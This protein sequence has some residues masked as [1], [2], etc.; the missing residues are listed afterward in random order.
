M[1]NLNKYW[2]YKI[3][4][5]DFYLKVPRK[6]KY[7]TTEDQEEIKYHKIIQLSMKYLHLS[8]PKLNNF[9]QCLIF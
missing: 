1:I 9:Y 7:T 5:A 3:I 2:P 8:K 6:L 4:V